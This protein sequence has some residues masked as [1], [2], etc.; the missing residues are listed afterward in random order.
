MVCFPILRPKEPR[1]VSQS[2]LE[3]CRG[4]VVDRM[5]LGREEVCT[6]Y[7]RE[8]KTESKVEAHSTCAETTMQQGEGNHADRTH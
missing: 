3:V 7:E 4:I 8:K 6:T 2:R 5:H 1:Q